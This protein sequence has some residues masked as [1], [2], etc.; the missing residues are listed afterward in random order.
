MDP[1]QVSAQAQLLRSCECLGNLMVSESKQSEAA[2]L[3][4]QEIMYA[5]LCISPAPINGVAGPRTGQDCDTDCSSGVR[6]Q[7]RTLLPQPASC[8]LLFGYRALQ[9]C[10]ISPSQ[11]CQ[12]ADPS[13]VYRMPV[14]RT[15]QDQRQVFG[16][17]GH[18]PGQVAANR[19]LRHV[20]Q[21]FVHR[22]CQ[23]IMHIM[24][25]QAGA[26]GTHRAPARRPPRRVHTRPSPQRSPYAYTAYACHI[27]LSFGPHSFSL[28]PARLVGPGW[29]LQCKSSSSHSCCS[30]VAPPCVDAPGTRINKAAQAR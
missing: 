26:H 20:Q 25:V 15:V 7:R 28:F 3:L 21:G 5:W 11:L 1:G 14:Y 29:L 2:V 6:L 17:V 9:S 10:I 30:L 12:A 19:N 24:F 13:A 18:R 4:N 22:T 8:I 27:A 16:P 23:S